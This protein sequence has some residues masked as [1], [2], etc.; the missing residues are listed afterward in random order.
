MESTLHTPLPE[1]YIWAKEDAVP[2]Q[3]KI[4]QGWMNHANQDLGEHYFRRSF[5]LKTV[6]QHATLYV[7][8]PRSGTVYLNRQKV[9]SFQNNLD[10]PLSMRV[11][12]QDVSRFLQP[13]RNVLAI[14]AVRGM[15]LARSA[16]YRRSIELTQGKILLVKILPAKLDVVAPPLLISDSHWKASLQA[17]P[18][19]EDVSFND[20]AWPDVESF[21]SPDSSIEFLQWN[22]DAGLYNWPQYDGISPFLAQYHLLPVSIQDVYAGTGQIEHADALTQSGVTDA[23]SEFRVL[24]PAAPV[25]QETSPQILLDFGREVVGRLLIRSD[26]D[27]S[28]DVTIQYGESKQEALHGPYLG[29]D[30]LHI[31]AHAT[32]YGPKSA[33]RYALIHFTG[34][35]NIRYKSIELDG[36]EYPVKYQ[37]FFESSDAQLNRMWM[38]GA[39][40][41]HLC[42]QDDIWDAPKRD[43]GRWM[44]D[45]DVSGRTIED[46]FN[47]HFLM[48]DTLNRLIGNVPVTNNVNGI[49]GYSAFWIT[50]EAEYYR[51]TGS[52][53]QLMAFHDRLIQLMQYMETDLDNRNLYA[54]KTRSWPFVDW[55]PEL[56]GNTPEAFRATQMEFY[57]AFEQG[58][59]LLKQM[60]DT[61]NAETFQQRADKMKAAAQ[62]YLLDA[63]TNSFGTRW[64]TNAMAVLSGVANPSQYDAIWKDSLASVGHVKYNA[65]IITPYY[66]YY[67]VSAMA[68]MG[69]R[70]AALNWIRQYW[71]GMVDE[72]ATSFWEGYDP[73]WYKAN[74]HASLQA[75]DLSGYIVSLAHGWSTGVTPWLMEQVLGIHT[76]GPGFSTVDIRPDLIDLQW[77]R[78]GEPTPHG[79]LKVSIRKMQNSSVEMAID[80]PPGI[81]AHIY[82]PV[83]TPNAEVVVNGHIQSSTPAENGGRA[84][85][86][87]S[88][89]GHYVIHTQTRQVM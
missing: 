30:P 33:F 28:G 38:I 52:R 31:P 83:S 57:A 1:Q 50:G 32:A 7:A 26:S 37:G 76:T 8:G 78:G 29:V 80:L 39:Y 60:G 27:Q 42:M 75:D 24:L 35:K 54:N 89:A 11:V 66:N 15:R 19:W 67:V 12:S 82:V 6:P 77:A 64:Q 63:S 62:H 47:D 59:Y 4:G 73:S 55:S 13:G 85:I 74:F 17:A 10:M 88:K 51:H 16:D 58:V 56:H 61:S 18:G 53:Q 40:T 48:E 20:T 65:L 69:H 2:A 21:G 36:I 41:A 43:R 22:A 34:G 45:L 49:A 5:T 44:G 3:A 70:E 72:G 79:V 23:Q 14:E 71:G 86:T 87:V 84:M 46:V 68:K 81:Q 25:N 9:L